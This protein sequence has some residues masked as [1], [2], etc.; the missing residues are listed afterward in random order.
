MGRAKIIGGSMPAGREN[1]ECLPNLPKRK[2][3]D[4]KPMLTHRFNGFGHIEEALPPM[5][6]KPKDLT[7]PV[8]T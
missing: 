4:A 6:G 2:K 8:A 7:K 1:M 5:G 3:L